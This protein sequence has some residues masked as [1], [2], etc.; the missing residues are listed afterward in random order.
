M[1]S[2]LQTINSSLPQ[3]RSSVSSSEAQKGAT[4]AV[5]LTKLAVHYYRPDFTEGQ[6]KSLIRDMVEDLSMFTLGEIDGSI[7]AYRRDGNNRFFPTSGQL[8][9]PILEARKERAQDARISNKDIPTDRRPLMWWAQAPTLWL[10]HW[11]ASEVPKDHQPAFYRRLAANRKDGL[12]G[13]GE[14]D[15]YRLHR[16]W[17]KPSAST[18]RPPEQFT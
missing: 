15:F 6:A 11:Q 7:K 16:K 9:A 12:D 17:N 3:E 14:N 2:N 1:E 10:P 13:W 18:P 5:L 4:I 8:R